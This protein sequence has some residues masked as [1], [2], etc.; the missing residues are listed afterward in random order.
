[1]ARIEPPL[2]EHQTFNVHGFGMSSPGFWSGLVSYRWSLIVRYWGERSS[3][4]AECSRTGHPVPRVQNVD[5]RDHYRSLINYEAVSLVQAARHVLRYRDHYERYVGKR[6][7]LDLANPAYQAL[8]P[9]VQIRD[10]I[11]HFDAYSVG[12]GKLPAPPMDGGCVVILDG[13]HDAEFIVGPH[14]LSLQAT[15]IAINSL[16]RELDLIWESEGQSA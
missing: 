3:I 9:V 7:S 14:R 10:A 6:P 13:I 11:E 5:A 2:D 15:V 16:T 4:L 1:M 8:A 12:R